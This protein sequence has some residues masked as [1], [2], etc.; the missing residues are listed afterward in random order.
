M[1]Y[2]GPGEYA[3]PGISIDTSIWGYRGKD[4]GKR[5]LRI[6]SSRFF[7][8]LLGY[9]CIVLAFS[10][11]FVTGVTLSSYRNAR[12]QYLEQY[13]SQLDTATSTVGTQLRMAFGQGVTVFQE[14]ATILY[15]KPESL[16]TDTE[17]S[18]LWRVQ[19]LVRKAENSMSPLVESEFLYY[20]ND[21]TVLGSSGLFEKDFFFSD[22]SRYVD[23]SQEF[24]DVHFT[25]TGRFVLPVTELQMRARAVSVIPVVTVTKIQGN[26]AIHVCNVSLAY[27]EQLLS[28]IGEDENRFLVFDSM[29]V[30][31]AQQRE[32]PFS[33]QELAVLRE[34]LESG[35][36]QNREYFMCSASDIYTGWTIY[37][38]LSRERLEALQG[39][40]LL[41]SG[42]QII[43]MLILGLLL[44]L[45]FSAS[46]YAPIDDVSSLLPAGLPNATSKRVDEFTNIKK[47]L[48]TL[49][50]NE[51]LHIRKELD[52]QLDSARHSILLV[53][54]GIQPRNIASVMNV[55]K[56]QRGFSYSKF[57]CVA[58]LFEFSLKF[59]EEA[60]ATKHEQFSQMIP[61]VLKNLL[62]LQPPSLIV[63]IET[64]LFEIVYNIE[65]ET[66]LPQILHDLAMLESPF[67]ADSRYYSISIGVGESVDS[68]DR[69]EISHKQ[70]INATQAGDSDRMFK[71][72]CFSQLPP[73]KKIT[74]SFYDQRGIINN[75][76]TAKP[77]SLRIFLEDLIHKN[78]QRDVGAE[79]MAELFRQILLVG[80][81]VADDHGL[82]IGDIPDY[83]EMYRELGGELDRADIHALIP[84]ICSCFLELQ[85]QCVIPVTST[86][87]PHILDIRRYLEENYMKP[88]SLTSIAD[89]LHLSAKYLSRLFKDETQEN[90]SAAIARIRIEK[91]KEYL[92][93]PG[94]KIGEIATRVGIDSRATFLRLFQKIEGVSP[95]EYRQIIIQKQGEK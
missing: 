49:M 84:R 23:Y 81:R 18:E 50:S 6:F 74:F 62:P 72:I 5:K 31:L 57:V 90:L 95:S 82:S 25:T 61:K 2:R 36:T 89:D 55:L 42:I 27:I 51:D 78:E 67:A 52:L 30:F 69:L 12:N 13:Q 80:R 46:L 10:G 56:E 1:I 77:E 34:Q 71:I 22:I 20:P 65:D 32:N 7:V 26:L 47:G 45:Y 53:L 43:V 59:N 14:S 37:G 54:N 8:R 60:G 66:A 35:A 83:L 44:V 39:H 64:D 41:A 48:E 4:M 29:G 91:A 85:R 40:M 93:D 86:E 87:N 3:C 94:M 28:P 24:W 63:P 76:E 11:L 16:R 79:L 73:K 75:I 9:F 68:V 92:S 21:T 70:A 19:E 33:G 17:R 15:F 88:L 38:L 58:V